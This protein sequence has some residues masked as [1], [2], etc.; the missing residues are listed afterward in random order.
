MENKIKKY[1]L[2]N[3]VIIIIIIGLGIIQNLYYGDIHRR[4]TAFIGYFLILPLFITS[5]CLT[6]PILNY[7]IGKNKSKNLKYLYLTIPAI[8][9]I[10][11]FIIVFVLII[12]K[13]F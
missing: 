5:I 12:I 13:S 9:F 4:L 6:I 10:V 11:Y 7:Y 2:L 1:S 3:L 8:L